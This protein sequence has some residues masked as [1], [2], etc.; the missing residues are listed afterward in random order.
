MYGSRVKDNFDTMNVLSLV[1]YKITIRYRDMIGCWSHVSTN[2]VNRV[3][4][5][6]YHV[7][8]LGRV[9]CRN[10]TEVHSTL[11]YLATF[12]SC[13]TFRCYNQISPITVSIDHWATLK[14]NVKAF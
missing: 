11:R 10:Y 6:M 9:Q 13:A 7:S 4:C 3:S 2:H 1:R 8:D 14:F 5:I 12:S